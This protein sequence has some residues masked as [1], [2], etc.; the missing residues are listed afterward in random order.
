MHF[1]KG[2][3][4]SKWHIFLTWFTYVLT[5]IR[6]ILT[7]YQMVRDQI[8]TFEMLATI[9]IDKINMKDQNDN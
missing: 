3:A 6:I 5:I 2:L 8:D 9:L 1:V 7:Q 4:I